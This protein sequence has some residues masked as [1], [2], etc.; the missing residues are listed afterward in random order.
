[1][2]RAEFGTDVLQI[3]L[4]LTDTAPD[5][6]GATKGPWRE[7]KE[8]YLEQLRRAAPRS[9]LVA[10]CD[11]RQNLGD[12]IA[13]LRVEGPA[14]LDRFNAGPAEQ[15][16]YFRSLVAICAD[17]TPPKLAGELSALLAELA[18]HLDSEYA[19]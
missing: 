10:V 13:D 9:R 19:G 18:E 2:I 11:K 16:W 17:V 3:V 5:E 6:A 1:M 8:R 12:L 7:R 15:L 14:T 4:D